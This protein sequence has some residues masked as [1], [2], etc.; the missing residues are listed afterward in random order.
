MNETKPLLQ[1]DL[2]DNQTAGIPVIVVAGGSSTRMGQ[3]K[4]LINVGGIPVLVRTLKVFQQSN[5]VGNIVLVAAKETV[6]EYQKLCENYMITK[7]SDIVE[8]GKDRQESVLCGLK[9]LKDN[10]EVVLIHDAARPFVNDKIIDRV[11]NGLKEFNAVTPVVKVKDTIKQIAADGVVIKTVKRDDLV[12]VQTPQGVKV[13]EYLSALK[14]KDLSIFTDDV[15][16][17]EAAG[18]KVLT[19]EGD[20]KNIKITTPED[21]LI[22]EA[23]LSEEAAE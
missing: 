23:F 2:A 1:Y 13:K 9:Q 17:F 20:Y 15:S 6:L 19:V 7:V 22:A 3:N 21:V 12:Q 16:I 11:I 8:G 14:D 18:D 4:L 10:D 5:R